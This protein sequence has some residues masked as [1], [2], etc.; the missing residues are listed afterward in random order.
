MRTRTGLALLLAAC[1]A[2]AA[3]GGRGQRTDP[4][5]T[6]AAREP[7]PVRLA[8]VPKAVGFDFWRQVR[9]GAE[10]AASR[11][12]DVTIRWDGV[13]AETDVVGQLSVAGALQTTGEECYCAC[14]EGDPGNHHPDG[15]VPGV[16][17]GK[18]RNLS[19]IGTI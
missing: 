4:A 13:T 12:K 15:L 11:Q 7:G 2:T 18:Q 10:C 3:C 17:R 9:R 6:G 14:G 19:C 5:T 16:P 1:L 8:V